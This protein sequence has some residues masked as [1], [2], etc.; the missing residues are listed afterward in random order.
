M[1]VRSP[2]RPNVIRS[3][4]PVIRG[5]PGA[6]IIYAGNGNQKIL[7]LGGDDVIIGG[8][9]SD[10]ILG[11]AG[12]DRIVGGAG[13]DDLRGGRGND[14]I[15]AG[16]G[17]DKLKGDK[18]NDRL[19][20]EIGD[21]HLDGGAG[22]DHLA[23]GMG[24]DI[25]R[26]GRGNDTLRGDAGP[27][28]LDGG[29]G[30][31]TVSFVTQPGASGPVRVERN[32]P[33]TW[34][35]TFEGVRYPGSSYGGSRAAGGSGVDGLKSVENVVGS[36]G[37][38]RFNGGFRHTEQGPRNDRAIDV[39]HSKLTGGT[40]IT[41]NGTSQSDHLSVTQKGDVLTIR[42]NELVKRIRV[43]GEI[44]AIQLEG[45]AG[46]DVLKVKGLSAE[47]PVT[48]S[49]GD[50]DDRLVGGRGNDVLNDGAGDDVLLGGGGDD[51]LTNS[52]GRDRLNGGAGSDLLVSSSIDRG[53]VL[54]G[55]KGLDNVSFAQVGHEFAVRA[56]L[57]GTAQRTTG[58]PRARI[59][60]AEDLEGTEGD[61]V[62]IGNGADNQLLGRGGSDTLIGGDGDD[63]LDARY[64]GD[65]DRRLDGGRGRDVA[66]VDTRDLRHLRNVEQRRR[67]TAVI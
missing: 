1:K 34:E 9:G 25:H 35:S 56:K 24:I 55:G 54:D 19:A 5:T 57:S 28:F 51:G 15:N 36:S 16:R 20:G 45:N 43:K 31:D 11:G 48:L 58:G 39:F 10:R 44:D 29:H 46:N 64:R 47:I 60:N 3:N 52:L 27:D 41:L 53:D 33:S 4:A 42:A 12:N 59:R 8:G 61:D 30:S 32:L 6:D 23:G 65:E 67:R 38:D 2:P 22:R 21:D 49:G 50:G 62:L 26:G 13:S 37:D 66:T 18:G 14:R 40:T 7:G 17:N 63:R